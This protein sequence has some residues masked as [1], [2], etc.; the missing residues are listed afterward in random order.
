M[1]SVIYNPVTHRKYPIRSKKGIALLKKYLMIGGAKCSICGGKGVSKATCPLN[2][3]SKNPNP[4][5]HNAHKL[6]KVSKVKKTNCQKYKKN[7]PPKCNDQL[8]CKWGKNVGCQN[9]QTPIKKKKNIKIVKKKNVKNIIIDRD[10][11]GRQV[12]HDEVAMLMIKQFRHKQK[13]KITDE[14]VHKFINSDMYHKIIMEYLRELMD[15]EI[16]LGSRPDFAKR[17]YINPSIC[18]SFKKTKDPKCDDQE[19]CEWGDKGKWQGV[20]CK[21]SE[22]KFA[23]RNETLP[24]YE[25]WRD[26]T[27]DVL[28]KAYNRSYYTSM[29]K[30][31]I[32]TWQKEYNAARWKRNKGYDVWNWGHCLYNNKI[33]GVSVEF[34]SG[35]KSTQNTYKKL[36][37]DLEKYVR[38]TASTTTYFNKRDLATTLQKMIKDGLEIN[39][40]TEVKYEAIPFK[41]AETP[42]GKPFADSKKIDHL[43]TWVKYKTFDNYI[44][45]IVWGSRK[46]APIKEEYL[47]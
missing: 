6:V 30:D 36:Y 18:N 13:L 46:S 1:Y 28:T 11:V 27:T 35:K 26:D 3:K 17:P 20:G 5:K 25:G 16:I 34:K 45:I 32:P 21:I 24:W 4:T 2:P 9:K 33:S 22:K 12:L 23:K 41:F 10:D 31:I 47:S 39:G 44:P 29:D 14:I 7:K 8:E 37:R 19:L 38:R 15:G 43:D 40:F 42:K